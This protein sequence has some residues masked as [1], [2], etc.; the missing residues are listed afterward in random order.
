M[1]LIIPNDVFNQIKHIVDSNSVEIGVRLIGI[2]DD[3]YRIVHVIGPGAKS[4]QETYAYEC[5]NEH[6]KNQYERVALG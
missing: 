2:K 3:A 6:F 5:D 4:V 1:K